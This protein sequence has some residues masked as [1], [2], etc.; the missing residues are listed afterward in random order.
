M[1]EI[2]EIKWFLGIRVVRDRTQHKIWL[3]QDSYIEKLAQ[4]F[5][6]NQSI[7]GPTTPMS[8]EPLLPYTS[9][10]TESEIKDY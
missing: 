6:I 10:T 5:G 3:C 8:T 1:R 2:G 9:I 4:K 7:S